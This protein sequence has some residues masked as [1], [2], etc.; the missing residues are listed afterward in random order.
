M[1]AYDKNISER[2]YVSP[3]FKYDTEIIKPSLL[4]H[5]CC[6]PCSAAVI[7]ELIRAYTVTVF[8]YNPNIT[9]RGEYEKRLAGQKKFIDEYN[10]K[11]NRPD[12]VAFIEGEY[13]PERF[14][15]EVRGLERLP[16]GGDRCAK[17][18]HLRLEKT[19]ETASLRGFDCFTTTL[20]VSPHKNHITINE[21]GRDICARYG[22]GFLSEDHKQKDGYKRSVELSKEYSLYR[23]NYCG[24]DFSKAAK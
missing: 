19:A 2:E 22:I 11:A 13:E 3:E 21:I 7:E 16:E 12:N 14:L 6:G 20:T 4:L 15:C 8:F 1:T 17:C 18:F 24:C 5:S 10:N 23:Q 9:D